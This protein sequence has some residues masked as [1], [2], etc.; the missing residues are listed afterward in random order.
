[1][2]LTAGTVADAAEAL[3]VSLDQSGALSN[4]DLLRERIEEARSEDI[5]GL[6]DRAFVLHY[7]SDAVRDLVVSIGVAPKDVVRVLDD[8]DLQRARLVVLVC[9][10]PR[11]M[12]R[13]LQVVSALIQVL[14]NPSSV[15]RGASAPTSRFGAPCSRCCGLASAASRWWTN[16]TGSSAC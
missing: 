10:P 8:D 4:A 9:A 6:A 3:C 2:P 1:M 11:Q 12:A 15:V 16:P 7:R 14:S 5:V 13:H